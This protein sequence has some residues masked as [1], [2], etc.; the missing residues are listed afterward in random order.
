MVPYSVDPVEATAY[1]CAAY[2]YINPIEKEGIYIAMNGIMGDYKKIRK[3]RK[4]G[5][6]T[7]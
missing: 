1:L 6:F 4:K 7:L 3:D 2:G 5:K